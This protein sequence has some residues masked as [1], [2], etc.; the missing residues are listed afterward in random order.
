MKPQKRVL[1]VADLALSYPTLYKFPESGLEKY[2]HRS[3]SHVVIFESPYP[4]WALGSR[5]CVE[6]VR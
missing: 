2:P 3:Q 4:S 5:S 6:I 1:S